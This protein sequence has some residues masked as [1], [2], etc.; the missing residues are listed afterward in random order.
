MPHYLCTVITIHF[1]CSS[2]D[3]WQIWC[4]CTFH[5]F[6]FM[7][8]RYVLTWTAIVHCHDAELTLVKDMWHT[9]DF[10]CMC[11]IHLLDIMFMYVYII[12]QSALYVCA[13]VL[14]QPNARVKLAII[15]LYPPLAVWVLSFW[16]TIVTIIVSL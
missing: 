14:L 4:M 10:M 16:F 8:V 5:G 9:L 11:L 7:W 15:R 2:A 6:M 13:I 12:I 3:H 1:L